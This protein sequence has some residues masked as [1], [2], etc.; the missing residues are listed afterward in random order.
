MAAAIERHK[1]IWQQQNQ[2]QG[3]EQIADNAQN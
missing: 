3:E 2:Q 1:E